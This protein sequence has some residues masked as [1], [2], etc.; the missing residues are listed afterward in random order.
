MLSYYSTGQ[1]P[2]SLDPP[3]RFKQ[4]QASKGDGESMYKRNFEDPQK[5]DFKQSA[6]ALNQEFHHKQYHKINADY[7]DR[8]FD[9]MH[10]TTKLQKQEDKL[11]YESAA[12]QQNLDQPNHLHN[13]KIV[14]ER[15]YAE[16]VQQQSKCDQGKLV[17]KNEYQA[18]QS[19]NPESK[20]NTLA[21]SN[22]FEISKPLLRINKDLKSQ[23]LIKNVQIVSDDIP[24]WCS[25][26]NKYYTPEHI[27]QIK[28][29]RQQQLAKADILG[30]FIKEPKKDPDNKVYQDNPFVGQRYE[31]KRM[32]VFYDKPDHVRGQQSATQDLSKSKVNLTWKENVQSQRFEPR[33][34][35]Q[36]GRTD[37]PVIKSL[38]QKRDP[39]FPKVEKIGQS[40]VYKKIEKDKPIQLKIGHGSP[41]TLNPVKY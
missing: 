41:S 17:S 16:R 4:R 7:K 10:N 11:F 1:F 22:M 5:H 25:S 36:I 21:R 31:P 18:T 24:D 33:L 38:N 14:K 9:T 32:C 15:Q 3:S 6:H 39:N 19:S 8:F 26:T 34:P 28:K 30:N 27:E 12:R 35:E 2:K 40:D 13:W 20:T 29:Q 23:Q 37:Q